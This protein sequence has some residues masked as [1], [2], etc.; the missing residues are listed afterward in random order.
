MKKV[1]NAI[2]KK[3]V[4]K[5][6]RVFFLSVA[7]QR[8]LI[9]PAWLSQPFESKQETSSIRAIAL[10]KRKKKQ[11]QGKQKANLGN[12]R[13]TCHNGRKVWQVFVV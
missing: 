3:K 5:K 4:K 9:Y 10:K 8:I 7:R 13:C 6:L 11:Q 1:E 2:K 12:R